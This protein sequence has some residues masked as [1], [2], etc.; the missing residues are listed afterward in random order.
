MRGQA[1][2]T[3]GAGFIG[4]HLVDALLERGDARHGARRPLDRPLGEP[5]AARSTAAPACNTAS[6]ADAAAVERVVAAARPDTC[7]TSRPRS[8]SATRSPT[9]PRRDVDLVGTVTMLEAARQRGVATLRRLTGGAIYGDATE[10]PTPETARPRPG[11]PYAASKA[12]AESYLE[13]YRE[14]HG[15]ST[16]RLRLSN[17]YGPRPG[18]RRARRDRDLLRRGGRRSRGDDLR[19]RRT[20]RATSSTSATRSRRSD[21]GRERRHR[22]LQHRDRAGDE[23]AELARTLGLRTALRAGPAGRGPALLPRSGAAAERLGWRARTPLTDGLTSTA[24]APLPAR[25]A[26]AWP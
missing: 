9:R 19:R 23:R 2:V 15:L 3:G 11:S 8:T 7:S 21:R 14:L 10:I 13:L 26:S 24:F 16:F 25:A 20:R 5:R 12:A 4:S 22:L 18:R 17:V 6:V 1:L